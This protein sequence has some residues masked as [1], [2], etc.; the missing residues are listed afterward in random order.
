VTLTDVARPVRPELTVP[1]GY[2]R[3]S[4]RA[5]PHVPLAQVRLEVQ[6]GVCLEYVVLGHQVYGCSPLPLVTSWTDP[7]G[8]G[9]GIVGLVEPADVLLEK[10]EPCE[11]LFAAGYLKAIGH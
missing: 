11:A 3:P 6:Q 9:S 5:L 2:A 4:P 8:F 10:S 7:A 1:S